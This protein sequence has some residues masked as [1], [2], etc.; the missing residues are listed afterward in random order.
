MFLHQGQ[1][2]SG[3]G[4][5]DRH[6]KDSVE[7]V[8]QEYLQVFQQSCQHHTKSHHCTRKAPVRRMTACC[9][10]GCVS[11]RVSV[12]YPN[13]NNTTAEHADTWRE[14]RTLTRCDRRRSDRRTTLSIY[15]GDQA[16]VRDSDISPDL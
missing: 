8:Y 11:W 9:Q 13:V 4:G 12:V 3:R 1:W 7:Q 15:G 6:P 16:L 10:E 5:R 2:E 14:A